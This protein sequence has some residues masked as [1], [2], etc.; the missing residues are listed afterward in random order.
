MET[1]FIQK[2]S[3][4]PILIISIFVFSIINIQP[5]TG[6]ISPSIGHF[7]AEVPIHGTYLQTIN[8]YP[9]YLVDKNNDS[10]AD[11]GFSWD[12]DNDGTQEFNSIQAPLIVDL[13]ENGFYPGDKIMISQKSSIYD[14]NKIT[15]GFFL[16]GLFSSTDELLTDNWVY[17]SGGDLDWPVVGPLHRV[18]GAIDAA[19]GGH[20]HIEGDNSNQWKQ[21]DVIEN[22]IPED[23]RV[24]RYGDW[25]NSQ[26]GG[27]W[28]PDAYTFNNGF[29]ITI[30]PGANF[31]FFQ[32]SGRWI[33]GDFGTCYV[34]IDKDTDKDAIPD[35]WEETG[36]DFNKDGMLDY[37]LPDAN[38]LH[39]DL[40]VEID[41]MGSILA[42]SEAPAQS[43]KNPDGTKGITLHIDTNGWDQIIHRDI[44]EAFT[45]FHQIKQTTFGTETERTDSN[46]KW[47]LV[48]KKWTHRYCMFIH[49]YSTQEE[50]Q[51]TPTTSSGLAELGGNDFLVSLGSWST[52]PGTHDEQ[53]A[54]F[55]HELG[56]TL[57]LQHGGKDNINYK[58]N[59]L[60]IMNYLFQLDWN[61]ASRP[62]DYSRKE[63]EPLD[64]TALD[65]LNGL[66]L[67]QIQTYSTPWYETGYSLDYYH[68]LEVTLLMPIDWDNDGSIEPDIKVNV[69]NFPQW[70]YES[71]PG[72]VLYGWDDWAN[73][74]FYFQD[75]PNFAQGAQ[76][77]TLDD[78]I[79]WELAQ[80]IR[81]AIEENE[82][83]PVPQ[84]DDSLEPNDASNTEIS[85]GEPTSILTEAIIIAVIAVTTGVMAIIFI[86]KRK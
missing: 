42:F 60:S 18:P 9:R 52:N 78:D 76:P 43:V 84:I 35:Y 74:Q 68:N 20:I 49:Q 41:Y 25:V 55:M 36:I 82:H 17:R 30:P 22:D 65:E 63:L 5:I 75:G 56:H 3:I 12:I 58:P 77:E 71:P 23:F 4:I 50:G 34:T 53:A 46:S 80:K 19:L 70:N 83:Y 26:Q 38:Y 39:K 37:V 48:A 61:V 7:E 24:T 8:C 1:I 73:L 13:Q 66:G 54:T 10:I 67:N 11:I 40:Y 6:Q 44:F 57:G 2:R 28:N 14:Q 45:D 69:N 81:N 62:L 33:V 29:W 59:Y 15:W 72:E 79:T 31:L 32:T 64:E 27:S 85:N 21:G 47:I 86:R 51:L 16:F